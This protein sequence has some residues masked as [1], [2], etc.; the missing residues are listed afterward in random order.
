VKRVAGA[1]VVLLAGLTVGVLGADAEVAN[2]SGK[3]S[4][5]QALDVRTRFEAIVGSDDNPLFNA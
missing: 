1:V 3:L 4:G 5:K 2:P